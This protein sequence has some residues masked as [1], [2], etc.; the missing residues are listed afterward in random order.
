MLTLYGHQDSGHAYKAR[1]MLV[2]ADIPHR[3]RWVDIFAERNNRDPE[4]MANARFNEVPLLVDEDEAFVQSGAILLHLAGSI[5]GFGAEDSTRLSRCREWLMWEANK[6]GM[7]LPQLR[8]RHK[9]ND[10][11]INDGALEWLTRRYQHDVNLLNDELSDGRD[12]IVPGRGP[13]V[14]DFSLCGYLFLA[15]EAK[16]EVPR[17][18]AAWLARIQSLPRWGDHPT[19]LSESAQ[20]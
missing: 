2:V 11:G 7:C 1:L 13:S 5:K 19:L 15:D 4:F 17:H 20:N 3:Y 10:D 12:W 6:I 14:A 16:V 9:F 18:V 8:S